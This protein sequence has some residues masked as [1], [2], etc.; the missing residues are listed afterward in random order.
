MQVLQTVHFVDLLYGICCFIFYVTILYIWYSALSK[1]HNNILRGICY[2]I[3]AYYIDTVH[4]LIHV[5][6]IVL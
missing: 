4:I 2:H 1:A 6:D 3:I 5:T